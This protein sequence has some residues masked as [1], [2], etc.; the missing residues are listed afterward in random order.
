MLYQSLPHAITTLVLLFLLQTAIAFG[1]VAFV[2]L[3]LTYL[4]DNA[5]EHNSPALIGAALAAKQWGFQW[6]YGLSLAVKE[7]AFGWWFG[8]SI[9]SPTLFVLAVFVGLFPRRL[10][11]AI[12]RQ[13][14]DTI[15]EAA[16]NSQ[17]SLSPSKLLA[18]ISFFHSMRR[19]LTNKVLMFNIIVTVLNFLAHEQNYLQSRFLLLCQ[20]M[21]TLRGGLG[22]LQNA[23]E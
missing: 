2:T 16:T 15:I 22:E 20:V 18:D 4:D 13:A 5:R 3:G 14:A 21:S 7:S 9:I 8:W 19:L 10:P 1:F 23:R 12:V 6:G 17:L 11:H